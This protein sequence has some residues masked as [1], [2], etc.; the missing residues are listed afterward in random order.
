MSSFL[1]SHNDAAFPTPRR[2]I[3]VTRTFS[4]FGPK[5][6]NSLVIC[7]REFFTHNNSFLTSLHNQEIGL[8]DFVNPVLVC[9]SPH[10]I[11][12]SDASQR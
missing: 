10:D 6:V 4:N 2:M 9:L 1:E 3:V 8:H 11:P 12:K 5:S 7:C